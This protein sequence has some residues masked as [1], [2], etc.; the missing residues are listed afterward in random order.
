MYISS[1]KIHCWILTGKIPS[2]W[3]PVGVYPTYMTKNQLDYQGY[4]QNMIDPNV[5]VP[6]SIW[7]I[8]PEWIVMELLTGGPQ[9]FL[10][11]YY[12]Q[13]RDFKWL[14]ICRPDWTLESHPSL[15]SIHP[16]DRS[17]AP[18]VSVSRRG[19][20]QWMGLSRLPHLPH[21]QQGLLSHI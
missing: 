9:A 5:M 19:Q 8:N 12:S 15:L 20:P 7:G 10:D 16:W 6:L 11:L 17:S 2:K 13:I 3:N 21:V 4:F 1:V 14:C 18:L